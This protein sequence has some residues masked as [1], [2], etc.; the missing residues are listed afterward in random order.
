[1]EAFDFKKIIDE[2]SLKSNLKFRN[3]K[4]INF[5]LLFNQEQ[6]RVLNISN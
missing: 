3:L 6:L 4:F 2:K 1:M 5:T